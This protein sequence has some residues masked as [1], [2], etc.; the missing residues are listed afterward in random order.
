M[1]RSRK[2]AKPHTRPETAE[3][4]HRRLQREA[5]PATPFEIR[6]AESHGQLRLPVIGDHLST[7]K[8]A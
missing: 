4:L 2:A 6:V 3:E 5:R 8:D 1:R 7:A